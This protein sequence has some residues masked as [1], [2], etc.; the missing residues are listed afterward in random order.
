M[1]RATLRA[2]APIWRSS[3]RTPLSRV[4]L[5]TTAITASSLNVMCLSAS[6]FSSSWRGIRYFLAISAFSRSV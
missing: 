6:P 4:Y 3:C 5:L 2:T 1:R